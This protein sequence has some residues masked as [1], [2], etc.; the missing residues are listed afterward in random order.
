MLDD[1]LDFFIEILGTLDLSPQN[2]LVNDHGILIGEGV[3]ACIH[4]INEDAQRPPV[5]ALPMPLIQQDLGSQVFRCPAEGIGAGLDLLGEA[6]ISELEVSVFR[7]QQI[8]G[9]EV[10]E[11][12]VLVVQVFEDQYDLR[13]VETSLSA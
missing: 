11:D 13:R 6:E 3:D 12:D 4:L 9:F 7:N 5:H 2:V 1:G 10:S 8:L